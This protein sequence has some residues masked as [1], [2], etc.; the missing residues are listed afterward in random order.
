MEIQNREKHFRNQLAFPLCNSILIFLHQNYADKPVNQK[1]GLQ[2][3]FLI[4]YH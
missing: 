4:C 2:N 1:N 3:S